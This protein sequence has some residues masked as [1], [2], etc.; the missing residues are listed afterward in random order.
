VI[1]NGMA[2]AT[3][4]GLKFDVDSFLEL[5]HSGIDPD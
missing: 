4:L 5:V 3:S 1:T 2:L